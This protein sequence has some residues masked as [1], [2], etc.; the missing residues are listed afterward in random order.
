MCGF[1][2]GFQQTGARG[3]RQQNLL[4]LAPLLIE[5]VQ[6]G[7]DRRPWALR[8]SFLPYFSVENST[9][10]KGLFKSALSYWTGLPDL[11]RLGDKPPSPADAGYFAANATAISAARRALFSTSAIFVSRLRPSVMWKRLSRR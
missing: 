10:K 7:A 3:Q 11:S 5:P 4:R 1:P 6:A 2:V 9:E 8:E